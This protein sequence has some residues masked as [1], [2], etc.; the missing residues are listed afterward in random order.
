M[1]RFQKVLIL[2]VL[3]FLSNQEVRAQACIIISEPSEIDAGNNQTLACSGNI[4]PSTTTVGVAM[5]GLTWSVLSQPNGAN[6]SITNTG[7]VSNMTHV[8]EYIFELISDIN[9]TCKDSVKVTIPNC[10]VPCPNPNC[11]SGTSVRKL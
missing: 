3:A 4:A 1:E 10:V 11:G 7:N 9:A 5:S 2:C 8:G 6:V